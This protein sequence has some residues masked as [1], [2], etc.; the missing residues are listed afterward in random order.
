MQYLRNMY[1]TKELWKELL[2]IIKLQSLLQLYLKTLF[3]NN[4][5]FPKQHNKIYCE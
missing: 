2:I 3:Y 1:D 5:T 4:S